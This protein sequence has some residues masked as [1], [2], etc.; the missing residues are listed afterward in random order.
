MVLA[1]RIASPTSVELYESCVQARRWLPDGYL[2]LDI[3]NDAAA[4]DPL[5]C[6]P[7]ACLDEADGGVCLFVVT[8]S[9]VC[10]TC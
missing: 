5:L 6:A 7:Q 1:H 2:R 8:R 3:F 9:G 4:D 10:A